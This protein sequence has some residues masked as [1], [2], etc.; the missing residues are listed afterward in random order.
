MSPNPR[1][2]VWQE[3]RRK[4]ILAAAAANPRGQ[5]AGADDTLNYFLPSTAAE[6]AA[7]DLIGADKISNRFQI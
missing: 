7:A 2:T 3:T 4:P 6:A 1:P 5:P